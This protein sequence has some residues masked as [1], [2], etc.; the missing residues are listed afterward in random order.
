MN[1][2]IRESQEERE[3]S[4]EEN[5]N[6][7]EKEHASDRL[8]N[9]KDEEN[10]VYAPEK[11]RDV[12]EAQEYCKDVAEQTKENMI[13]QYGERMGKEN[14]DRLE[15]HD[16]R[17]HVQVLEYEDFHNQFPGSAPGVIGLYHEGTVYAVNGHEDMLNH[18]ITHET[19]HLCS[20]KEDLF[21]EREDGSRKGTYSSGLLRVETEVDPD[22]VRHTS[23]SN[24]AFNEGLTEMYTLRELSSR[25]DW[26]AA[27]AY[28]AYGPARGYC[29]RLEGILDAGRLEDAYYGGKLDG[30]RDNMERLTGDPGTFDRISEN[31][32]A[33]DNPEK[34]DGARAALESDFMAM[35]EGR[36]AE[37]EAADTGA[38]ETGLG[39]EISTGGELAGTVGGGETGEAGETGET[40]G[41]GGGDSGETGGDEDE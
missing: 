41:D 10:L 2:R 15:A 34:A 39:G 12:Q 7:K 19:T 26:Q 33:L 3:D 11:Y 32:S 18:T 22:G 20:H 30:L 37:L 1:E 13:N 9:W 25:G 29:A 16:T 31:F 14:L 24:R 28:N 5:D 23:V 8:E 21:E 38:G 36:V 6:I 35:A 17:Q 27:N 40:G 4:F